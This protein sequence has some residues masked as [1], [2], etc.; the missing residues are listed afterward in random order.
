[1]DPS[2]CS[3][4]FRFID[5]DRLGSRDSFQCDRIFPVYRCIHF[6]LSQ[7]VDHMETGTCAEWIVWVDCHYLV[8]NPASVSCE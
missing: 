1:M 8:H 6:I 3:C 5:M 7:K 4:T 2:G